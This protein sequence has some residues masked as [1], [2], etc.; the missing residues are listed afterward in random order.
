MIFKLYKI[1][2]NA[3]MSVYFWYESISDDDLESRSHLYKYV[4]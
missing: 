2:I 1:I 3:T 4:V